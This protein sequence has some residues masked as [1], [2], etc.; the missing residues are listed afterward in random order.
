MGTSS[1]IC[2][3][4]PN[5]FRRAFVL[6]QLS[7]EH[8]SRPGMLITSET[9]HHTIDTQHFTNLLENYRRV[10]SFTVV[11]YSHKKD[12]KLRPLP[13]QLTHFTFLT[14]LTSF[15]NFTA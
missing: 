10:F 1:Q 8:F 9:I 7:P 2:E 14:Y 11:F 13:K 3:E 6:F 5:L 15:L 4:I 12:G